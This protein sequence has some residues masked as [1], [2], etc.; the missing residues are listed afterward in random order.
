M[1]VLL[2]DPPCYRFMGFYR[3]YFPLGLAQVAAVI[4]DA[5]HEVLVYD[6][7]HDPYGESMTFSEA[8]GGLNA[9]KDALRNPAHHVWEEYRGILTSFRPDV[10]GISVITPKVASA[11]LLNQIAKQSNEKIVTVGG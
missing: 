6:A 8:S 3:H 7:D 2:V 5:G 1:K 11:L 9:Y 10:I 4:R